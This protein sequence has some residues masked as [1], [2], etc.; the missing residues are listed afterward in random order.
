MRMCKIHYLRAEN[1]CSQVTC[2]LAQHASGKGKP[3]ASGGRSEGDVPFACERRYHSHSDE[4]ADTYAGL[5]G[6][7]IVSKRG[8]SRPDGTPLDVDRCALHAAFTA[9]AAAGRGI[10]QSPCMHGSQGYFYVPCQCLH[11]C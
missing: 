10:L 9:A 3:S 11:S 1:T 7:I 2:E 6:A 4:A 8:T 5:M